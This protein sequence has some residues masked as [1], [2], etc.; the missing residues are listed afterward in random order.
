MGIMAPLL[1][2]VN[3][4]LGRADR[5]REKNAEQRTKVAT[6]LQA[7]SECL[8]NVAADLRTNQRAYSACGELAHYALGLPDAVQNE[9]GEEGSRL[10]K[11]LQRAAYDRGALLK[12]VDDSDEAQRKLAVMEETAGRIKAMSVALLAS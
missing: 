11:E 4:I 3:F 5:W 9:L 10:L 12:G 1:G 7:I 8:G 6:Y 2:L